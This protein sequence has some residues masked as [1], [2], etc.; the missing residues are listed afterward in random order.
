MEQ[1]KFPDRIPISNKMALHDGT[2]YERQGD[3]SLK[4]TKE[5]GQVKAMNW[6]DRAI[7]AEKMFMALLSERKKIQDLIL[8]ACVRL[9]DYDFGCTAGPLKSCDD[10]LQIKSFARGVPHI[11]RPP[12]DE[13]PL[14]AA[15]VIKGIQINAD[16]KEATYFL[17][18]GHTIVAD[19]TKEEHKMKQGKSCVCLD[20]LKLLQERGM[21]KSP[22]KDV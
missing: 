22:A 2:E 13:M 17:E 9:E 1:I 20:C 10:F 7:K 8:E 21:Y 3:G 5:K 6:R 16:K 15:R 12:L 18:C 14:D 4:K 19:N 11:T